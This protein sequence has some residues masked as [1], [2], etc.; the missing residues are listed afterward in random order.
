[1]LI[2]VLHFEDRLYIVLVVIL[3]QGGI[4]SHKRIITRLNDLVQHCGCLL[5]LALVQIY[6]TEERLGGTSCNA[7]CFCLEHRQVVYGVEQIFLHLSIDHILVGALYHVLVTKEYALVNRKRNISEVFHQ[8][9]VIVGA[10]EAGLGQHFVLAFEFDII[11]ELHDVVGPVHS[12]IHP[13][14][15]ASQVLI[16]GRMSHVVYLLYPW[17]INGAL[18]TR[19]GVVRSYFSDHDAEIGPL[20]SVVCRDQCSL[21][22][23]FRIKEGLGVGV[24]GV[25]KYKVVTTCR[26]HENQD[27]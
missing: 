10:E 5:E 7:S 22:I 14:P 25:Y 17:D 26:K 15:N 11:L 3:E 19:Q 21:I 9:E 8:F 16:D 6:L 24:F 27:E 2:G 18:S 1:M 23:F 20:Q 13:P 12:R 4:I